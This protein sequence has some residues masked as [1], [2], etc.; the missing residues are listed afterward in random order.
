MRQKKLLL[1]I[2][3]LISLFS[4][5][6]FA[7]EE[8]Q[9]WWEGK[10]IEDIRFEGLKNVEIEDLQQ[11]IE[12]YTGE[13][14]TEEVFSD[15]QDEMYDLNFFNY[16]YAY[17]NRSS[18]SDENVIL[19]FTVSELPY[20]TEIIF[21]NNQ[22]F[23]NEE[24]QK[25]IETKED[26]FFIKSQLSKDKSLIEEKYLSKGYA[27]I[28]IEETSTEDEES[29]TIT[30]TFSLNEG[31]QS[32]IREIAFEGNESF[33]DTTLKRKIESKEKSLF[34]KGNFVQNLIE[35]DKQEILNF[36]R[37]NGYLDAAVKDLII[38][39]IDEEDQ[40]SDE[41]ELKL[42]FVLSEGPQWVF[43]G[44]TINGNTIFTDDELTAS[45]QQEKNQI[46]NISTIQSD[47]NRIADKYYNEGYIYNN[48]TTQEEK[49]ESN[50]TISYI[51][52]VEEKGQAE[53]D[54]IIL[55]GNTKTKDN[56]ILRELTFSKGDIFSKQELMRSIQNI[57]NTGIIESVNVEP[58]Y[59][60]E[61][62]LI[63]LQIQVEESNKVDLRFGATFGGQEEFPVSGF[64]DWTDKN[65]MGN[66]QDLTIGVE[67][68]PSSQDIN[69]SFLEGW[70]FEERWSGGINA[71]FTH[72]NHTNI[73]Q[74]QMPPYGAPDPY[75]SDEEYENAMAEGEEIDESY[76]MDYEKYELG[77]GLST[78]YTFHTDLGRFNIGSGFNYTLSKIQYDDSLYRPYDEIIRNNFDKW[79]YN[80]IFS[81]KTSWDRRDYIQNPTKGFLLKNKVTLAGGY[82]NF[83]QYLNLSGG[84][85][86]YVKNQSMFGIYQA[87]PIL[88]KKD[89]SAPISFES[90][91]SFML[92]QDGWSEDVEADTNN[93]LFV[94]GMNVARGWN[95]L[96]NQE[97]LWHNML[98]LRFPFADEVLWGELYSS[99]TASLGNHQEI[100]SLS[101]LENYL[102]SSGF[103]IKLGIQGLPIGIYLTKNYTFNKGDDGDYS[104]AWEPGEIFQID[105]LDNSGMK[106]VF[107]IDY[108]LF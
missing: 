106:L 90:T 78:G 44:Y 70:L 51:V 36:Y 108:E 1:L 101:S 98:E 38:E 52:N 5:P 100:A 14:L 71:S 60:S 27:D 11:L 69:F 65:F 4:H 84:S 23:N 49:N 8:N 76:L 31:A 22:V 92:S 26:A 89:Y 10:T 43:G 87:I 40:D 81:I 57:Y 25:T 19:K 59:G 82:L 45:L 47:I 28:S 62:G 6:V 72:S 104:I 58:L 74:D 73:L 15:I 13:T 79:I 32:K 61:E 50:N 17:A 83:G 7:A 77:V 99:A 41:K 97:V 53:I 24:L 35:S 55:E 85:L 12:A 86:N 66:G 88:P 2:T 30:I 94:D 63:D 48:L 68:S 102:F 42:T 20:V 33:S 46:V 39:A 105:S 9:S 3:V 18:T 37:N 21:E 54:N 96:Y 93:K 34:N 107:A 75:S 103:G 29:G 64:L 91:F 95:S 80:N 16:F 67:V 56:V